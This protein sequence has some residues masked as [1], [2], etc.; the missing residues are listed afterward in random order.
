MQTKVLAY[1]YIKVFYF[2]GVY[3][4][5]PFHI[6]IFNSTG[7]WCVM[8]VY[9]L[10][11]YFVDEVHPR[12][13]PVSTIFRGCTNSGSNSRETYEDCKSVWRY[14]GTCTETATITECDCSGRHSKKT[15]TVQY[16]VDSAIKN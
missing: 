4:H 5:S 2:K 1:V 14:D 3:I 16:K 6:P 11:L 13:E 7:R 10:A 12:N 8:P 9:L 15:G